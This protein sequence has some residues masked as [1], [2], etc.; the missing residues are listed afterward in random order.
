M[1]KLGVFL[2]TIRP[3]LL[4][5]WYSSLEKSCSH[6]FSVVFAGPFSPSKGLLEKPNV[7]FIQTFT[8]PT[9][10]AHLAALACESTYILHSTDDV[11][12]LP[13]SVDKALELF[14]TEKCDIVNARYVESAGHENKG[15]FPLIYWT[16]AG[17]FLV[18]TI[19]ADFLS[20][21][22]FIMRKDLFMEYGGFDC[23]FEYLTHGAA[24]LVTRIQADNKTYRHSL[25]NVTTADWSGASHL[26]DHSAIA[27][28]QTTSDAFKYINVWSTECQTR[29]KIDIN[30]HL[31]FPDR[32]ERRFKGKSPE[33]YE[34]MIKEG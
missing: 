15:E 12:F 2:P 5:K 20:G 16:N 25:T 11:L 13:E 34:E 32:W 30:N 21:A 3:Q 28:A 22:H 9:K 31:N 1:Y 8:S 33:N 4:D 27:E 26:I 6:P 17:S 18:R 10:A 19:P 7:T 14:D 24:D 23:N 29:R